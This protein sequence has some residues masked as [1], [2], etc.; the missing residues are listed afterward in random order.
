M[1]K[2]EQEEELYEEM[3]EFP[4]NERY[5]AAPSLLNKVKGF[6][7]SKD[8]ERGDPD[9]DEGQLLVLI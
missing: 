7:T 9:G 4:A 8:I 6:E 3:I 5:S 1:P 2:K